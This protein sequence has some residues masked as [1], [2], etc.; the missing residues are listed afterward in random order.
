MNKWKE[1]TRTENGRELREDV[2]QH[3]V[4]LSQDVTY[5]GEHD[6][7]NKKLSVESFVEISSSLVLFLSFTFSEWTLMSFHFLPLFR[8]YCDILRMNFFFTW[9]PF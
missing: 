1:R 3:Q 2:E 4:S 6:R 7:R 5:S 8:W 9:L